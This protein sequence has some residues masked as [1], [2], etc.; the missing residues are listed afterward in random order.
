MVFMGVIAGEGVPWQD[1]GEC[2]ACPRRAGLWPP[3]DAAPRG[4]PWPARPAAPRPTLPGSTTTSDS[5]CSLLFPPILYTAPHLLFFPFYNNINSSRTSLTHIFINCFFS[6]M[7]LDIR[8][9]QV[10]SSSRTM[11]EQLHFLT[12]PLFLSYVDILK[13]YLD[14]CRRQE[15]I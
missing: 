14:L 3:T 12:V 13:F 6:D 1:E 4:E 9:F 15:Y 10:K 7:N 2:G 11:K 8:F 5:H